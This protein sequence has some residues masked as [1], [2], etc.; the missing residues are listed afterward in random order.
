MTLDRHH[1]HIIR[2]V[3]R[4]G[5]VT[6]AAASLNLSQSALSHTI[7]KLENRFGIKIW[8]RK[9][10]TLLYSQV[11]EYL[12]QTAEKVIGEFEHAEKVIQEFAAGR[13]GVMR[14][15]MECH[16]CEKWLMS[17]IRLFLQEWPGVDIELVNGFRFNGVAALNANEIDMLITPD[18]VDNIGLSFF[19]VFS[20]S[21]CVVVSDAHP[22]S[23]KE[24]A[25]PQ[26]FI[27]EVL[28]TVP[29]SVNRLDV[30]TQFLNPHNILP[31]KRVKIE[32]TDLILQ[33][34]SANRG[35]AVLP[36]WLIAP[37]ASELSLT[38]L[39]LGQD[40][41]TKSVNVGIRKADQS[42]DYVC[43]FIDVAKQN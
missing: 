30:Y 14:I 11:G 34:V 33:L 37:H 16:P 26:D 12:L 24:C 9:G 17:K 4:L 23:A 38:S 6:A 43:G 13:R 25:F 27:G 5:S 40:G 28:Y 2:E 41:L 42:L 3:N 15:G 1:L 36:Q 22:L 10:N 21:L 39:S 20:Y 19:P 29:V 31:L 35:I 18:P 7:A 32:S 8:Q